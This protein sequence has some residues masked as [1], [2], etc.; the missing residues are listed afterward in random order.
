MCHVNAFEKIYIRFS[1]IG[2]LNFL[3]YAST[4]QVPTYLSIPTLPPNPRRA[5]TFAHHRNFQ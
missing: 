2:I 3:Y 5:N 4:Q 1:S